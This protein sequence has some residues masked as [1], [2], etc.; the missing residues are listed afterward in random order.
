MYF[1]SSCA[2]RLFE[3]LA[4]VASLNMGIGKG[5]G[6][7]SNSYKWSTMMIYILVQ[8]FFSDLYMSPVPVLVLHHLGKSE[9]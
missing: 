8:G 7:Y 9:Y 5:S 4:S 1:L 3:R 6:T 2:T